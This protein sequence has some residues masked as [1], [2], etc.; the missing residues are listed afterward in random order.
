MA[1]KGHNTRSPNKSPSLIALESYA[2]SGDRAATQPYISSARGV[3]ARD[4]S[5]I[6][7][8]AAYIS[9]YNASYIDT[10]PALRGL[11]Y[12]FPRS[13]DV[14]KFDS[15]DTKFLRRQVF[16]SRT[17][18]QP[19]I[20]QTPAA[21]RVSI[22]VAAVTLPAFASHLKNL[23]P[24]MAA[25]GANGVSL[26][27][28]DTDWTAVP[29]SSDMLG[30]PWMLEYLMCFVT[31]TV[32]TGKLCFL[33][34]A[35]HSK[36]EQVADVK[37]T[38][39]PAAHQ[40]YI[41]GPTK[42]LLVLVDENTYAQATTISVEGL[43]NI[44]VYR[45]VRIATGQQ[46]FAQAWVDAHGAM[47]ARLTVANYFT[48]CQN[49]VKALQYMESNLC[50]SMAFQLAVTM[51]AELSSYIP[52]S[53]KLHGDERG[54]YE[55]ELGGGWSIGPHNMNVRHPHHTTSNMDEGTEE[56][57]RT[58]MRRLLHGFSFA[59]VSPIQQHAQNYATLARTDIVIDNNYVGTETHWQ[60]NHPDLNNPQYQC[61][62]SNSAYRILTGMG[63]ILKD[64]YSYRFR[65]ADGV[66]NVLAMQGVALSLS[67][68]IA[69][70][71][72]DVSRRSWSGISIN[73]DPFSQTPVHTW[74]SDMTHGMVLLAN[75][76][77]FMLRIINGNHSVRSEILLYLGTQPGDE[78]WGSHVCQPYPSFLQ[79]ARQFNIDM[80]G[81]YHHG[82]FKRKK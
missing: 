1:F 74:V 51:A 4:M 47:Y 10:A 30:N 19:H 17:M 29:V 43:A 46:P 37:F 49:M 31:S 45:G 21:E 6:Q 42:L 44:P 22:R 50:H 60:H 81:E 73:E 75:V 23:D 82:E 34:S 25:D 26:T 9:T 13:R 24:G 58:R 69:L 48:S 67:L 76:D 38:G 18:I 16:G 35:R 33:T 41:P 40:V 39:M 72:S 20:H 52:E 14:W 11:L 55:D 78:M 77:T 66:S 53:P 61:N 54:R 64:D 5:A 68:G 36:D 57:V 62:T 59:S 2:T 70:V 63:F 7:E 12:A 28:M 8:V 15:Y 79:W 65:N 56:E 71:K 32:W 27:G 80:K 3:L